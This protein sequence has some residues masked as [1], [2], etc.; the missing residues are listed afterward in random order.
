MNFSTVLV[1]H[2][3]KKTKALNRRLQIN[4]DLICLTCNVNCFLL[5][6]GLKCLCALLYHRNQRP[7]SRDRITFIQY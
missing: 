7:E 1:G 5:F 4:H 3:D 2:R 6:G